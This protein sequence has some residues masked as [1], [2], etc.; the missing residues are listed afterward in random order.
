MYYDLDDAIS[1]ITQFLLR[2]GAMILGLVAVKVI[3][4]IPNFLHWMSNETFFGVFD[5]EGNLMTSEHFGTLIMV[6][7]LFLTPTGWSYLFAAIFGM[8]AACLGLENKWSKLTVC[9]IFG[10]ILLG[11][12]D[13]EYTSIIPFLYED[14]CLFL[15]HSL[16]FE[17]RPSAD[18]ANWTA[19][20]LSLLAGAIFWT[21]VNDD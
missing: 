8:G 16:G 19:F 11:T 13:K 3:M 17:I 7:Y 21:F 1:S 5:L 15:R 12:Y 6:I 18:A 4:V 9:A 14:L 2:I 20:N 10:L